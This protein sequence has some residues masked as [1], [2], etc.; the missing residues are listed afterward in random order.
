MSPDSATASVAGL[1]AAAAA[2]SQPLLLL[3][4]MGV[5]QDCERILSLH[6]LHTVTQYLLKVYCEILKSKHM[7]KDMFLGPFDLGMSDFYLFAYI[8][9]TLNFGF[10]Y[11]PIT[12]YMQKFG[13]K[14]EITSSGNRV[15][16]VSI[17]EEKPITFLPILHYYANIGRYY[18]VSR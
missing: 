8:V 16:G 3:N 2:T 14:A 7:R 15:F 4:L 13:L 12:I 9:Q 18:F 5:V 10:R 17:S 1:S 6:L 11:R